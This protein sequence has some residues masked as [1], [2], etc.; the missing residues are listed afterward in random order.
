MHQYIGGNLIG[1]D[2]KQNEVVKG[3]IFEYKKKIKTLEGEKK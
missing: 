3:L 1:I 2:I